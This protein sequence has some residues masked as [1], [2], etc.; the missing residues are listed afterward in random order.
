MLVTPSVSLNIQTILPVS[1][2]AKTWLKSKTKYIQPFE[3]A[4]A[5][6]W[7]CL[8]DLVV[9]AKILHPK[10][11]RSPHWR[12]NL[13]GFRFRKPSSKLDPVT[14]VGRWGLEDWCPLKWS[15]SERILGYMH[16]GWTNSQQVRGGILSLKLNWSP[17]RPSDCSWESCL[18]HVKA[19]IQQSS[20]IS[21][22]TNEHFESPPARARQDLW[23]YWGLGLPRWSQSIIDYSNIII[24]SNQDNTRTFI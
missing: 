1:L 18:V 10:M 2:D 20:M 14:W 3:A 24:P 17:K 6:A 22:P 23:C 11:G 21:R 19:Q 4:P 5:M 13:D 8:L 12:D 7:H 16:Q 15:I 9:I